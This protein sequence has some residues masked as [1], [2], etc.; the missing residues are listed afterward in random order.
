MNIKPFFLYMVTTLL[1]V[2]LTGCSGDGGGAAA[3]AAAGVYSYSCDGTTSYQ[4]STTRETRT[5]SGA[6]T[7]IIHLHGKAGFATSTSQ[8]QF[9]DGLKA[10]GYN[11]IALQMPWSGTNWDGTLCEGLNYLSTVVEEEHTAGRKVIVSGHSMGGMHTMIYAITSNRSNNIQGVILLAPGHMLHQSNKMLTATADDVT[12]AKNLIASG[13]GDTLNTFNT[14]N[15]GQERP[16]TS[17]A[18]YYLSY[19]DPDTYPNV[20]SILPAIK[21]P[22]LWL[23]G[24]DD[25]L[26]TTYNMV[27]LAA[28]ITSS[29]SLYKVVAGDHQGMLYN[30]ATPAVSWLKSLGY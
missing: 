26:T 3:A 13:S 28:Q 21:L 10:S 20:N 8:A 5:V 12:L 18:R 1:T 6:T 16:L 29:N 27:S 22:V 17:T 25:S 11:L 30:A 24:Q 14:Y 15:N 2:L 9:Y 19:H 4:K 23:A 7:T